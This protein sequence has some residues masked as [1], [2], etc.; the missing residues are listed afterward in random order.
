MRGTL[1]RLSILGAPIAS[2]AALVPFEAL[3]L[4]YSGLIAPGVILAAC[5]V[6]TMAVPLLAELG[7]TS[8]FSRGHAILVG[9]FAAG[10]LV[11]FTFLLTTP[12]APGG[13]ALFDASPRLAAY[14][15]II[16]NLNF[17]TSAI[18]FALRTE[19]YSVP[20]RREWWIA[21]GLP[22]GAVAFLIAVCALQPEALP[23]AVLGSR[24]RVLLLLACLALDGGALAFLAKVKPRGRI[25]DALSLTLAGLV[26]SLGLSAVPY[27]MFSVGWLAVRIIVALTVFPVP[28]AALLE[29]VSAR[30]RLLA[31]EPALEAATARITRLSDRL[32]ALWNIASDDSYSLENQFRSMLGEGARTIRPG[33]P[34]IA[35]LLRLERRE[36]IVENFGMHGLDEAQQEAAHAVLVPGARHRLGHTLAAELLAIGHTLRWPSTTAD[37]HGGVLWSA[38]AAR[39]AIGTPFAVDRHPYALI[40]VSQEGLDDA[41]FDDDDALYVETL[42]RVLGERINGRVQAERIRHQVEHDDLTGLPNRSLFNTALTRAITSGQPF[43]LAL[44]NVDHFREVN[45]TLGYLGGDEVLVGIARRLDA[46]SEEDF[47]ARIGGDEFRIILR[48]LDD[49]AHVQPRVAAYLDVFTQ[50]FVAGAGAS[51][52]GAGVEASLGIALFPTDS[53]RADGLLERAQCALDVAQQQGGG[54]FALFDAAMQTRL[55]RSTGLRRDI[56]TAIAEDHLVLEYQ[57]SFDMATLQ[58]IGCEALVR[59]N[60]PRFGRIM[61]DDFV[62]FAL[63][64]GLGGALTSWVV[65]RAFADLGEL[66]LPPGFYCYV[67]VT[68]RDLANP[69]FPEQFKTALAA[70]PRLAGHI[71]IEITEA[72]AM[73]NAERTIAA[74]NAFKAIGLRIALDDFGTGYSSLPHLKRLPLD[75]IKIDRSFLAAVPEDGRDCAIAETLFAVAARFGFSTL[76][77]GI[78]RNEQ[79]DWVQGQGCRH[80]QGWLYSHALPLQRLVQLVERARP[81]EAMP[82]Y[83]AQG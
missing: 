54:R 10:A 51:A 2:A 49:R 76:A 77:E 75:V 31:T 25:T 66:D 22:I 7:R 63:E 16:L 32:M 1:F 74:L 15:G 58:P 17:A 37:A 6:A 34:M 47:V 59:W 62:P 23:N 19:R 27:G 36:L 45:L 50:P 40:F 46:V 56:A 71:G 33:R 39:T 18:A 38:L 4:P 29:L 13:R 21:V 67:N 79:A 80:G 69:L 57:P 73:D 14:L 72:V 55:D 81:E 9:A 48:R 65:R 24:V 42:A 26:L 8:S 70:H 44:L 35:L 20:S 28:V 11:G 53:D 61:P 52:R 60:H 68:T 78:E 30:R 83:N 5:I 41:P 12:I 64:S 82:A 43:A 3:P